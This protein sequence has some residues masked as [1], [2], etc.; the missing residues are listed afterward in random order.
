MSAIQ[1]TLSRVN[2]MPK[3]S[4]VV[5]NWSFDDPQSNTTGLSFCQIT[6]HGEPVTFTFEG[7]SHFDISTENSPNLKLQLH[8][9]TESELDCVF[10]C[11]LKYVEE[12]AA[13]YG[14]TAQEA[15]ERFKPCFTK[16]EQF[17]ASLRVKVAATRY[18][19]DGALA[20]PPNSHACRTWQARV[21]L[22]SLWFAPNAWGVSCL[23]TDLSEVKTDIICPF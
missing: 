20:K 23:A 2:P 8:A 17:P 10:A 12:H 21:H 22:K 3:E 18:W 9:L 14:M 13:L 7:Q 6:C 1:R 19:A 15:R 4:L 5:A 11:I 16:K